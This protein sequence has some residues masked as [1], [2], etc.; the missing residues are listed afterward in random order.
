MKDIKNAL[1]ISHTDLDG[2]TAGMLMEMA[3]KKCFNGAITRHLFVNY[4][5]V[6]EMVATALVDEYDLITI[7]D[8]SVSEEVAQL[9]NE[10]D[11]EVILIDHHSTAMWLNKYH[12]ATVE[13]H[14]QQGFDA[15]VMACATSL[16]YGR[17][18]DILDEHSCFVEDLVHFVEL[19]DTWAWKNDE[20]DGDNARNLNIVFNCLGAEEYIKWVRDTDNLQY[21]DELERM[22][23]TNGIIRQYNKTIDIVSNSALNS[24]KE[25]HAEINGTDYVFGVFFTSIYTSEVCSKILEEKGYDFVIAINPSNMG[26]SLRSQAVGINVAEIAPIIFGN[27]GGHPQASGAG[28]NDF[29]IISNLIEN[30][31]LVF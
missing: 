16:V 23:F 10:S 13:T 8:I 25:K 29:S 31:N 3:V 12:W 27:G 17:F 21:I 5:N 9:I 18:R 6:N 1:V 11:K 15:P 7:T 30:D 14:R 26:A 20:V 24:V 2:V 19:W 28:I 4:N 22:S